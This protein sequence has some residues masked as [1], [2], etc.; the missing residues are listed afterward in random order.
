MPSSSTFCLPFSGHADPEVERLERDVAF[1]DVLLQ[2]AAGQPERGVA[3]R[4]DVV[5]CQLRLVDLVAVDVG[6]VVAAEVE[7]LVA[8][9]GRHPQLGVELGDA[10]VGQDD[11][12]VRTAADLQHPRRLELD[13]RR[14]LAVHA[15][16]GGVGV[17]LAPA[18]H[19]RRRRRHHLGGLLNLDAEHRPVL[20]V[21]DVDHARAGDVQPRDLLGA[22]EGAVP[23]APVLEHPA[24]AHRVQHRVVPGDPGVVHRDVRA[25]VAADPVLGTALQAMRGAHR[26]HQQCRCAMRA[27]R[28]LHPRSRILSRSQNTPIVTYAA[29]SRV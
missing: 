3:D 23:A 26:A 2:H 11:V 4:D 16:H 25:F 22:E 14:R 27:V 21:A 9:G 24:V 8:P 28:H 10:E 15:G 7:D 1:V 20:G 6:A 13:A 17:G 18:V 29:W 5:L 12:V 19:G